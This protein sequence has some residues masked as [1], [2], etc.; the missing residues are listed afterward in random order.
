M[1]AISFEHK[2]FALA[3]TL[4]DV[5]S[6]TGREGA[7]TALLGD[8]LRAAGSFDEVALWPVEP[9]RDNLFARRGVPRVVLSTHLDTVPP[10]FPSREDDAAIHGRGACDAKGIAA[11]MA[12]AAVELARSGVNDFGLPH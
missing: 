7:A 12:V 5:D 11:A 2:L 8:F 6:T 9:G 1:A 10:F 3:R 4:I